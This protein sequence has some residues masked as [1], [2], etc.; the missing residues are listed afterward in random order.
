MATFLKDLRYGF[1]MLMRAPGFAT[2]A[3]LTLALG[4]GANTAIF[5]VINAVMLRMLPVKDPGELAV[6]GNPSRVHS[7]SNGTPRT[8]TVSCPLYRELRDHNSVFSSVLGSSRI[9][10]VAIA[11]EPGSAPERVESRLVSGNYFETLGL[12]PFAGRFFTGAE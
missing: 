3:V 4:I 10:G 8:D 1:R 9:D 11:I 6:V 5:T 2:V 7:W 12:S